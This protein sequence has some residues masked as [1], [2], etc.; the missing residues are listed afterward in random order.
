MSPQEKE[1]LKDQIDENISQLRKDIS[2]LEKEIDPIAPDVA[3]GR[4][5][6]MEAIGE[7]SIKEELLR[8][9]H[10]RLRK[11]L[12]TL[13]EID[14]DKFGVCIKCGSDIPLARIQAVPESK[15]C[16]NCA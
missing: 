9:S 14:N 6:R 4:L 3:I 11:L 2:G 16:I 8:T 13:E 10:E 12:S 1:E 7:K 5:S 15:K